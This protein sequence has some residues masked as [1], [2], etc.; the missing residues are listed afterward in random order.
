MIKNNHIFLRGFT[1]KKL[2]AYLL[3][4][5]LCFAAAGCSSGADNDAGGGNEMSKDIESSQ[6][7]PLFADARTYATSGGAAKR[8]MG[9]TYA[10][11][12]K[13]KTLNIAYFGGSVT[14]G[15][16]GTNGGWRT[17]TTNWFKEQFPDAQVN[18]IYA[19][20]GGTASYWGSF[21]VDSAVLKKNP[22]LVFVEKY[23]CM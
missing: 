10:R 19:A 4:M 7:T 21:R 6:A 13:D 11:L 3:A 12:T 16:G 2:L 23:N 1:M 15:V 20:I 14:G 17:L 5:A 9:N 18:E 22:D 8:N